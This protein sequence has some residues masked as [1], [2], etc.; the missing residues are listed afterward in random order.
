MSQIFIAILAGAIVKERLS[1]FSA[2]VT[3]GRSNLV[4]KKNGLNEV[5]GTS[6]ADGGRRAGIIEVRY[7]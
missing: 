6:T 5:V 3:E 1:N 7:M 2:E 4:S